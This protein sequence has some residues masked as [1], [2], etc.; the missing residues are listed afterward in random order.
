MR[1]GGG[2]RACGRRSARVLT[3]AVRLPESDSI[4][5]TIYVAV[6]TGCERERA[7]KLIV[8]SSRCLLFSGN[9]QDAAGKKLL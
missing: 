1:P 9:A 7:A 5:T 4:R 3:G 8:A 2:A 6:A